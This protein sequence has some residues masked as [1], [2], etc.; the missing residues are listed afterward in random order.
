MD[1]SIYT[2]TLTLSQEYLFEQYGG[3][4]VPCAAVGITGNQT[5][6]ASMGSGP[7][8]DQE[9]SYGYGLAALYFT[10]NFIAVT[11]VLSR[12]KVWAV[13]ILHC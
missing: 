8:P 9:D 12:V 2:V 4:V 6:T 1:L 5:C 11:F 3:T 13:K 7:F 10:L